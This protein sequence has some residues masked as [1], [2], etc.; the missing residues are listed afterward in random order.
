MEERAAKIG[1][2][3]AVAILLAA[4]GLILLGLL[5]EA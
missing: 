4:V 3:I 2:W 5:R 1:Q